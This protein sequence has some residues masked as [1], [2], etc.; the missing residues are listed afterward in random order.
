MGTC[1]NYAINLIGDVLLVCFL[2]YSEVGVFDLRNV[3]PNL[4]DIDGFI[5]P[6]LSFPLISSR[7]CGSFFSP[8]AGEYAL[9]TG[10]N[11]VEVY[12][13]HEGIAKRIFF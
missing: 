12:D 8:L 2:F 1:I 11:V 10:K 9:I 3:Q 7:I 5:N 13:L 4:S 6:V